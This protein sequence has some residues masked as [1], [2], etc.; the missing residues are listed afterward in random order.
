MSK[1]FLN[2]CYASINKAVFFSLLDDYFFGGT[3]EEAQEEV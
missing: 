2:A 1:I 3:G